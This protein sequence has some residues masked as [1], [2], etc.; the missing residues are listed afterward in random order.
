MATELGKDWQA[1]FSSFDQKASLQ[2]LWGRYIKAVTIDNHVVACKLQYPDMES[3]IEADLNQLTFILGVY[4]SYSKSLD[5]SK[6]REEIAERL[7]EELDYQNEAKNIGN[8][9]EIARK[10]KFLNIPEVVPS[11]TTKRLLTMSWL[12]GNVFRF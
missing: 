9:E 6:M 1:N 2:P 3:T 5:T 7:R 12:D 10:I 11:L 8:F 4:E